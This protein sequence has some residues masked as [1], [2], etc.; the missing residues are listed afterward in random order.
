MWHF[1]CS[2][3]VALKRLS[4]C[5]GD[6]E[7]VFDL[8]KKCHPHMTAYLKKAIPDRLHYRNNERIQPLLLIADEGWT[9]VQRGNKLPR[10]K[11]LIQ[12]NSTY[13]RVLEEPAQNPSPDLF[14][15]QWVI[16]ATTT[17]YT[18]CTP[19]WQQLGRVS[20]RVSR[21]KVYRAWTFTR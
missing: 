10:S 2:V 9:I 20:I 15:S 7:A 13:R 4:V 21:W 12:L 6:P 11:S 19:F 17:P 16:M 18:A 5:I 3:F 1:H 14:L 8:L